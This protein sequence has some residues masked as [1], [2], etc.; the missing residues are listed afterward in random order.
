M[1]RWS[2]VL[3]PVAPRGWRLISLAWI[4]RL[5]V[6]SRPG[7]PIEAMN[8]RRTIERLGSRSR[9]CPEEGLEC[10]HG[11]GVM[12]LTFATGNVLALRRWEESSIGPAYTSL[13]HRDP[14]GRWEFWSTADPES[15]CSRYAG[16][17]IDKTVRTPI[18]LT[19]LDDAH[20]RVVAPELD[21]E[22]DISLAATTVTRM[23][24][25][26]SRNL[27]WAV[28]SHPGFLKLMGPVGGRLLGVGRFNMTGRMPNRQLFVAAPKAIWIVKRSSARLGDVDL[29][30]LGPLPKQAGL[31]DFLIPQRGVI[32]AGSAY[33]E[34]LDPA[35][36][37]T[38]LTRLH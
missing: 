32:A 37:S 8:A 24:S 5:Q 26:V 35:V 31:G 3:S 34:E 6:G 1:I 10:F 30:P 23:M 38:A 22:W 28:R 27:P 14:S 7:L 16:A 21:F 12:G 33:F 11:Y 19:W 2:Q 20:L 4:P 13:W 29:G 18:E 17:A 25:F 9:G 36:H 15:S